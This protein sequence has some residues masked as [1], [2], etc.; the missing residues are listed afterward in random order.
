MSDKARHAQWEQARTLYPSAEYGARAW[1]DYFEAYPDVLTKLLGDT[2]RVYKA[3]Q[4]KRD[5]G[6]NP[7]GGRRR[8]QV[9]GNLDEL[10]AILTPRFS[11]EPFAASCKELIGQQSLRA[12]AMRSGMDH[13]EL[14]RLLR[15]VSK[16]TTY[17]L[18]CIAKAADVHPAYFLEWR[19]ATV[20]GILSEAM[21]KQPAL[22]IT[23]IKSLGRRP[24]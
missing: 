18:E 19:V 8:S 9:N 6:G 12:F 16:P 3:E 11:E 17:W 2:Y 21:A 14:S 24:A 7:A 13:R 1:A 5:G 23:A 20:V 15:G 4:A 10:W 22:S